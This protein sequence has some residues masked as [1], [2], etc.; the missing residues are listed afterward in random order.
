[1]DHKDMRGESGEMMAGTGF[2]M[3]KSVFTKRTQPKN[4]EVLWNE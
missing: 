1:M 2:L 3:E 4:V